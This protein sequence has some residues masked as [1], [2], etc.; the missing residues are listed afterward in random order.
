M[1]RPHARTLDRTLRRLRREGVTAVVSTLTETEA[2]GYHLLDEWRACKEAGVEFFWLPVVEFDVPDDDD[3]RELVPRV[4]ERI[5][6]GGHVVVHCRL[7]LGRSPM[8]ASALLI[9]LGF[10]VTDAMWAVSTGRGRP[11]PT[12][13]AQRAWL[14]R[15]ATHG[16]VTRDPARAEAE[17]VD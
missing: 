15:W 11:V 17:Q 12:R 4:A 1:G 14:R 8:I 6:R 3:A 16:G 5:E 9:E 10:G 13:P 2:R 7:G